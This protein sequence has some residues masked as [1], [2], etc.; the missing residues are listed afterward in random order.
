MV[1]VAFKGTQIPGQMWLFRKNT[2]HLTI[3]ICIGALSLSCKKNTNGNGNS[4]FEITSK[5]EVASTCSEIYL[6]SKY[7]NEGKPYLY[8]A[9]KEGGLKIYDISA[10][11]F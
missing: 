5:Y 9:A 7:D 8:V 4:T 10:T 3:I 11:P 6:T 2:L 1:P